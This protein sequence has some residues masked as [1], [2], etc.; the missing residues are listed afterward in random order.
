MT[1]KTFLKRLSMQT[2]K[3]IKMHGQGNDYLYIFEKDLAP[4]TDYVDLAIQ[5]S[6]RHFGIGSDGIVILSTDPK[7]DIKMRILNADGSEAEM[8]GTALRSTAALLCGLLNKSELVILTNSG[9][10]NALVRNDDIEVDMGEALLLEDNSVRIEVANRVFTGYY[11]SM[12]NPHFIIFEKLSDSD[13]LKKWGSKIE[14]HPYFKNKTNVEFVEII[15]N[16]EI[17]VDIWERGSGI[18]LACGTGACA[19]FFIANYLNKVNS[20]ARMTL[21]GGTVLVKLDNNKHLKLIGS[22]NRVMSGLYY[23]GGV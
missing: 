15:N 6:D 13:E 1:L 14:N 8:C 5:M 2:I 18:T 21:P 7:A 12:G 10:K 4:D 23:Y 9:Y 16:Q 20:E 3:F 19:S 17:K 22:V 11:V